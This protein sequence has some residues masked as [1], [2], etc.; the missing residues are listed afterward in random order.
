MGTRDWL[1]KN[2]ECKTNEGKSQRRGQ[3]RFVVVGKRGSESWNKFL[4]G[5]ETQMTE[6]E[7]EKCFEGVDQQG[8]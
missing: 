6:V 8:S 5:G 7:L 3:V 2:R 4:C 1:P